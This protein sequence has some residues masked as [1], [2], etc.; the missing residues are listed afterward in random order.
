[1]LIHDYKGYPNPLKTGS[2]MTFW[3]ELPVP[4]DKVTFKLYTVAE[5]K[6]AQFQGTTNAGDNNFPLDLTTFANELYYYVI[7]ADA[8]GK[9]EHKIG[10]RHIFR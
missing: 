10:K 1:M 3:Y 5:R 8:G 6:V 7:E 9:Q 2:I 4:V